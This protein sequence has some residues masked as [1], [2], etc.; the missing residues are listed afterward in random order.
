M[1]HAEL[2]GDRADPPFLNVVI[3]QD[4]ASR[5]GDIVIVSSSSIVSRNSSRNPAAAQE[6]AANELRASPTTPLTAP[7]QSP[8]GTVGAKCSSVRAAGTADTKSS[9][10]RGGEPLCVTIFCGAR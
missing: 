2:A 3:A 6:F 7:C 9:G 4:L 8:W 5:S 1:V 10:G